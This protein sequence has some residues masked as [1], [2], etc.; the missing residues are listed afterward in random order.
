M[1]REL[2]LKS[3]KRVGAI[4]KALTDCVIDDPAVNQRETLLKMLPDLAQQVLRLRTC[5]R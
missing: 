4:L 5:P 2:N 1:L 3:D